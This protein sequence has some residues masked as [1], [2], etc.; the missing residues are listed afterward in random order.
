MVGAPWHGV[1]D[2][3]YGDHVVPGIGRAGSLSGTWAQFQVA[4]MALAG[5]P[6]HCRSVFRATGLCG[7]SLWRCVDVPASGM[8]WELVDLVT[9]RFGVAGH[10]WL[11]GVHVVVVVHRHGWNDSGVARDEPRELLCEVVP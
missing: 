2:D 5:R 6:V 7:H 8:E 3:D 4:G 11:G 1:W 10:A 9:E